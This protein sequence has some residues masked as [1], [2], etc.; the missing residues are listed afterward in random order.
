MQ[1][2][3]KIMMITVAVLLT[4]VLITSSAVSGTFAKYASTG[5]SS[6]TA[7]VAKWGITV[8]MTANMPDG[9]EPDLTST[10]NAITFSANTLKM[11]PGRDYSNVIKLEFSG[12]AEVRLKVKIMA[13]VVCDDA[14]LKVPATIAQKDTYF[15]PMGTTIKATEESA[16]TYLSKPWFERPA[17][18]NNIGSSLENAIASGFKNVAGFTAVGSSAEKEFAPN[19]PINFTLGTETV[20]SFYLGFDWPSSYTDSTVYDYSKLSSYVLGS[21][22]ADA[23]VGITYTITVEQVR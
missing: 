17:T 4:L 6:S 13:N 11:A 20:D 14:K 22:P 2:I 9:F 8:K 15:V 7:R 1:K 10:D 5:E 16:V 3:N 23:N 12:T 18:S 21:F 19:D